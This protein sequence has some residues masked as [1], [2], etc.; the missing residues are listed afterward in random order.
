MSE[1]QQYPSDEADRFLVR[2]P[3]GMRDRIAEVA[4]ASGRSMNA[5]I[6]LRL[7]QSFEQAARPLGILELQQAL[8][9]ERGRVAADLKAMLSSITG[10]P[11]LKGK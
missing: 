2:M 1:K 4:K 8:A 6:V 3:P 5:E 9:E 11:K 10:A 7:E